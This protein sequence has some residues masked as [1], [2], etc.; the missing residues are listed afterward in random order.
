VGNPKKILDLKE[1]EKT[2]PKTDCHKMESKASKDRAL[3]EGD[4]TCTMTCFHVYQKL[5][6]WM[7]NVLHAVINTFV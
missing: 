4:I 7:I 2:K 6:Y 5:V 3:H 1:L